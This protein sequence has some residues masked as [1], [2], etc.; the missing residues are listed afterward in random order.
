[1][2]PVDALTA[3]IEFS[4]GLAGFSGLIFAIKRGSELGLNNS[5]RVLALIL[6]SFAAGFSSFVSMILLSHFEESITWRISSALV[7]LLLIG[8]VYNNVSWFRKTRIQ[9]TSLPNSTGYKVLVR[10][11]FITMPLAI[12]LAFLNAFGIFTG[13]QFTIY[14]GCIVFILFWGSMQFIQLILRANDDDVT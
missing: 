8:L 3:V 6:F 1:M 13:S 2:N 5:Y 12:V 11:Y 7:G 9:N 10:G 14:L 4:I